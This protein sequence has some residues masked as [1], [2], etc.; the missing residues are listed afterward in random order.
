MSGSKE[1]SNFP[2]HIFNRETVIAEYIV[3]RC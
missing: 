3:G 2:D 1:L